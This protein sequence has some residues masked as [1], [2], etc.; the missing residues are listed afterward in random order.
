MVRGV[1]DW[2]SFGLIWHRWRQVLQAIAHTVRRY[3]LGFRTGYWVVDLIDGLRGLNG[4]LD[5]S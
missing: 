4:F 1:E 2:V 3:P 5:T